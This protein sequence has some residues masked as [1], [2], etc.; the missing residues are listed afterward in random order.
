MKAIQVTPHN[1]DQFLCVRIFGG[2][3]NQMFQYAAAFAQARRL[4]RKLLL[5][6]VDSNRLGHTTFG[7]ANFA[8]EADLWDCDAAKAFG[9]KRLFSRSKNKH[10]DNWPGTH[11][12]HFSLTTNEAIHAVKAG[13]YLNGYFQSE[14]YFDSEIDGVRQQFS[15]SHLIND[16]AK[17]SLNTVSRPGSVSVHVR[18]GDYLYDPKVLKIHGIMEDHYYNGARALMEKMVPDCHFYIF[19]DDI[20]AA[21][22]LTKHWSNRTLMPEA[23]RMHDLA[24]MSQCNHHIIANSSFSW[25]G[26]WLNPKAHKQV[27]AP[28]RWF[29]RDHMQSTYIDDICPQGW[30]LI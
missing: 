8:L 1:V 15:L 12:R 18:R 17:D 11:F 21:D 9:L 23:F 2:L 4:D 19:S 30:I 5:H 22:A 14:D 13:C 24:L 3:G 29:T 10:G 26:A 20:E 16:L 27:I 28:R 6:V 7:L 25:W